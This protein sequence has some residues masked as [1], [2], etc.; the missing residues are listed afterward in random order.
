MT[1]SDL[2][3]M[4]AQS[5]LDRM[6]A[7][8]AT[9]PDYDIFSNGFFVDYTDRMPA[10]GGIFPSGLQEISRRENVIGDITVDNQ[11]NFAVYCLLPKPPEDGETAQSNAEWVMAFQRWV[12]DQSLS[13]LAPTFGNIDADKET[14]KA[15]N[16]ILYSQGDEGTA[17]YMVQLAVR[18]KIYKEA[19]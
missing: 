11:Y 8:I 7:W 1:Q 19:I 14:I 10:N 18:F 16:G 4:I 2:D 6:I 5:D 12:Q 17:L 13:H 15:Q 3:S 9:Y